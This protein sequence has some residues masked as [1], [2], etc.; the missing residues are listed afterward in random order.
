MTFQL[1][2]AMTTSST[3]VLKQRV[4]QLQLRVM[5]RQQQQ[6]QHLQQQSLL[7]LQQSLLQLQQQSLT[8]LQQQISFSGLLMM[9]QRNHTRLA[10]LFTLMYS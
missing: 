4:L 1:L 2:S 5:H 6:L 3:A 9:L 7:Q 8:H 10:M